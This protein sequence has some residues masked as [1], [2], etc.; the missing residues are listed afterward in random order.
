MKE[1]NSPSTDEG[2][3]PFFSRTKHCILLLIPDQLPGP[4]R[5]ESK[6]FR[7]TK[8]RY[9]SWV[10]SVLAGRSFRTPVTVKFIL[11]SMRRTFPMGSCPG[12]YFAA[13]F[14]VMIA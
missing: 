5:E 13:S 2:V 1:G 7:W 4:A 8:G 11:F 14:S 9:I 6:S 3:T 10:L 12:K